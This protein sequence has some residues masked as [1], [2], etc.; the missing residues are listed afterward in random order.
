MF[1]GRR[2]VSSRRKFWRKFCG[3]KIRNKTATQVSFDNI[4]G[5]THIMW[6]GRGLKNKGGEYG[7]GSV[8]GIIQTPRSEHPIQGP[9]TASDKW[10]KG[11]AQR[12]VDFCTSNLPSL[13]LTHNSAASYCQNNTPQPSPSWNRKKKQW[14]GLHAQLPGSN[15]HLRVDLDA[16]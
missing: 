4:F 16:C 7:G 15:P 13:Q 1:E 3:I 8:G 6:W 12:G 9:S 11:V 2:G 5:L 14:V 10:M